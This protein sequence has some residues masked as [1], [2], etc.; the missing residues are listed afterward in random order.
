MPQISKRYKCGTDAKDVSQRKLEWFIMPKIQLNYM[1][2]LKKKSKNYVTSEVF[3]C[4]L[5]ILQLC[6]AWPECCPLQLVTAPHCCWPV[7][8][9]DGN[10]SSEGG[11]ADFMEFFCLFFPKIQTTLKSRNSDGFFCLITLNLVKFVA[12]IDVAEN[13]SFGTARAQSKL[14]TL[15]FLA[16]PLLSLA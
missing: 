1:F 3:I 5:T 10:A 2:A 9:M 14:L 4:F 16:D 12:C 8:H 6:T 7:I 13:V 15:L 11:S